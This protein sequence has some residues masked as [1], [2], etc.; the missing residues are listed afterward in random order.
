MSPYFYFLLLKDLHNKWCKLQNLVFTISYINHYHHENKMKTSW[1]FITICE[2]Q[3]VYFNQRCSVTQFNLFLSLSSCHIKYILY[4]SLFSI[5]FSLSR[6]I[7]AYEVSKKHFSFSYIL[8]IQI[9]TLSNYKK[10]S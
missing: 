10:S 3:N 6:C 8:T 1:H 9:F 4:L 5:I 2:K 7:L